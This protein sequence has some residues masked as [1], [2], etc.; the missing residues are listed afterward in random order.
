VLPEKR[1]KIGFP[2]ALLYH[3]Y[4][5]M[6]THFFQALN[7]Q[8]LTSP[9]TNRDILEQGV[10]C[11]IDETCLAVKI[12]LG[13][14]HYLI[15]KVDYLFIP[16]I[17]SLYRE[18]RLCVRFLALADVVRNTFNQAQILEYNVDAEK[19]QD[20][21]AGLIEIGKT[22]NRNRRE[23]EQAY[24]AAVQALAQHHQAQLDKQFN[25][26]RTPAESQ[27]RV[28]LVA[29]AYVM[30]DA[31]LGK[32]IV[33]ILE[34]LGAQ[35]VYADVAPKEEA[36]RLSLH[37]SNDC[38]WTYNKE[39]LGGIEFYKDQVDGIVFLM[40]F[41]CGPDALIVSLC[42]HLIQDKPLCVLNLDELQG[43]AGLK[44]RLE[45]FLDI[46]MLKKEKPL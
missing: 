2:R 36:R 33:Q 21:L 39:L 43:D 32:T 17:V 19:N 45:S 40:A 22:L 26:L 30:Y 27:C 35:V 9:N 38:Y 44:T 16:R 46:L 7:C 12:F 31:L 3:K 5:P 6:W 25:M 1:V 15:G 42:Q 37:L 8:I 14:I 34:N 23:V 29:H 24:T 20:E 10:R 11:S 18:E 4:A 41:P 28:L 13:H